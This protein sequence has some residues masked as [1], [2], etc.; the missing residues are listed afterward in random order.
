V[1]AL[2]PDSPDTSF[3]VKFRAN[4]SESN[5][6]TNA[7]TLNWAGIFFFDFTLA[8]PYLECNIQLQDSNLISRLQQ[9]NSMA[10]HESGAD[11]G[12]EHRI[13]ILVNELPV[14]LESPKQSGLSIKEAAISQ[15]VPI[16]KNFELIL[17]RGEG[18]TE[19]I[20]DDQEIEVHDG[21][22]FVAVRHDHKIEILVNE[23]PVYVEGH[24]QTGLSV[25]EAAIAQK[26]P[27]ERD[28]VLSIE[29]GGGKTE[30]VGDDQKIV[31]HKHERFL[32]IQNDDN[33]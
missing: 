6:E 4:L 29:R 9:E 23:K 21:E 7:A 12:R 13:R 5:A 20:E 33:S 24:K 22:R 30:L 17:E 15:N 31:V 19:H 28:F 26:V 1:E 3:H 18:K 2:T 11:G 10:E 16:E 27:I 25:K 32:A 8:I 14:H